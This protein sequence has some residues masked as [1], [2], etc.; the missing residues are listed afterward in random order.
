M[1]R[2]LPVYTTCAGPGVAKSHKQIPGVLGLIIRSWLFSPALTVAG[3]G[4]IVIGLLVAEVPWL[5]CAAGASLIALLV[6]FKHWYYNER[7]LCIRDKECAIGTVISE[8][9]AATDGDRKLNLMLAPYTQLEIEYDTL[10]PHIDRNQGMLSDPAHFPA[11]AT[12]P[13]IPSREQLE[14]NRDMFRDYIQNLRNEAP[15]EQSPNAFNQLMIGMVDTLMDDPQKNFFNRF[16]RK[17]ATH[18][19]D[20]AT[21]DAIPCD[22]DTNPAFN[23]QADDAWTNAVCA[24]PY[25][26]ITDPNDHG[27]NP[28]FR[29]ATARSEPMVP[30]LH[31]EIEG[32]R[33]EVII[34]EVITGLVAFVAVCSW[35]GPAAGAAAGFLA[36][37]IR[38]IWNRLTGNDGTA[39]EPDID[40]DN[41]DFVGA[42]DAVERTGDVIVVYGAWIMD[43]EHFQ[44]F[45][46][47]PVRA[48]YI[49]ATGPG[50]FGIPVS[51]NEDQVPVGDNFDP[52]K[53]TAEEADR[54]CKLIEH[55][56]EQGPDSQIPVT[57]AT[58]LS[59]GMG[60]E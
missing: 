12:P 26:L 36:W 22:N 14:G 9:T 1:P 45:E 7:L 53:V 6:Q 28:M 35:L 40:W 20:P 10:I 4:A 18:I 19:T 56:E 11:G 54:I 2:N 32:N 8:P 25:E 47:H 29:Y 37:L 57:H 31:C 41:P 58:A 34:D 15:R 48:Y 55:A 27:P 5:W 24:N 44:Y 42:G 51:T 38:W 13:T 23:W 33:I 46:I 50:E 43:T 3:L 60:P 16:F 17:D 52:S 49:V 30:Y 21:W 39:D 59:Y